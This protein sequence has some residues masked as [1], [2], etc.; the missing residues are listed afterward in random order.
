MPRT[1]QIDVAYARVVLRLSG[2]IVPLPAANAYEDRR[3][4]CSRRI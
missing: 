3:S 4:L 2:C 1:A